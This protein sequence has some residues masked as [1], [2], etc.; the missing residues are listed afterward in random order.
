MARRDAVIK[1]YHGYVLTSCPRFILQQSSLHIIIII[2]NFQH[3]KEKGNKI[4]YKFTID[5]CNRLFNISSGRVYCYTWSRQTFSVI[6]YEFEFRVAARLLLKGSNLWH[7]FYLNISTIVTGN[8]LYTV[9]WVC[10]VHWPIHLKTLRD[11]IQENQR[12]NRCKS[13]CNI[14]WQSLYNHCYLWSPC[15]WSLAAY[16]DIYKAQRQI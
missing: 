12:H 13:G 9:E 2:W 4:M 10:T 3:W 6:I 5:R 8:G 1:L 16:W 11:I 14:S 7:H 15:L